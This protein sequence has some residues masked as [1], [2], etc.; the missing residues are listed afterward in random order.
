LAAA[1]SSSTFRWARVSMSPCDLRIVD[2]VNI[3]KSQPFEGYHIC[4]C[5]SCYFHAENPIFQ[6]RVLYNQ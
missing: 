1:G 2:T 4:S 5:C 3:G 6:Q